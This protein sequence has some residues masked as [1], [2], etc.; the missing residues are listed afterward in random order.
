MKN[1]VT[2]RQTFSASWAVGIFLLHAAL[3]IGLSV[4]LF[5]SGMA[6]FTTGTGWFHSVL[7]VTLRIVSPPTMLEMNGSN[8]S[9]ASTFLLAIC[10]SLFVGSMA[11]FIRAFFRRP[12]VDP[13]FGSDEFSKPDLAGTPW[14]NDPHFVHGGAKK[15][16]IEQ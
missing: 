15:Q 11:G 16:E 8:V 14:A 7:S 4:L 9:S 3:T 2:G 1:S 6:S 12:I 5:L 10:W 13:E